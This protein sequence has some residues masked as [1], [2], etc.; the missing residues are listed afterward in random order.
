MC[1]LVARLTALALV[2]HLLALR[3]SRAD[4]AGAAHRDAATRACLGL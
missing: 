3:R 2:R 4:R 1:A